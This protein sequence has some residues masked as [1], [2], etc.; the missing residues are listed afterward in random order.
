MTERPTVTVG[1][2]TAAEEARLAA[3]IDAE[4]AQALRVA[5][6]EPPPARETLFDDV[7]AR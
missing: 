3:A 5:E 6:A 1:A 4:F 7:Y 2:L